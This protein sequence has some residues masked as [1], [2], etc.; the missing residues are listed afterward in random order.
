M[1]TI[2]VLNFSDPDNFM[3]SANIKDIAQDHGWWTEGTEF[4]FTKIYSAGEY[5]HKYYSGR[6]MWR[7][8]SLFAPSLGLN[9]NY[10]SILAE[11]PYPWAVTPDKK[12]GPRD[13]IAI[14][15]DWYEGTPYDMRGGLAAGPFGSPNRFDP[16]AGE[17]QVSGS[18]ERP[19]D[20][21][22]TTYIQINQVRSWL[23]NEVGGVFYFSQTGAHGNCFTPFFA[24]AAF[25]DAVPSAYSVGWGGNFTRS[26]S[27]WAFRSVN[28]I[29]DLKFDHMIADIRAEQDKWETK[30]EALVAHLTDQYLRNQEADTVTEALRVHASDVVQAWWSLSDFLIF[31]YA[32]GYD[33]VPNVGSAVGYPAWWLKEVGYANGPPP[34]VRRDTLHL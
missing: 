19:I 16:G 4:D 27:Y 9:A 32:D 10:D 8:L 12:M 11:P 6:R 3:F 24:G 26:S 28:T 25:Q 1:F 22:R 13:L 14:H 21:F 5:A 18:W 20:L 33:N 2:R 34:P 15:R 29:A 31:R 30:G 7:A 23:P 17:E